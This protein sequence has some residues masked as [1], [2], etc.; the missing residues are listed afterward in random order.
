VQIKKTNHLTKLSI[1]IVGIIFLSSFINGQAQQIF[2]EQASPIETSYLDSKDELRDYI[3]DTGDELSIEFV[4]TPELSDNY[5]ID[6]QGEIFFNRL[7]YTYVRGLTI[8]E[9]TK[10]LEKRYEEFLLNPEI[11]IRITQFKPVRVAVQG[12]VRAPVRIVFPSF[13]ATSLDTNYNTNKYNLGSNN[14]IGTDSLNSNSLEFSSNLDR[15]RIKRTNDYITTLSNA[16]RGAGGLT[17]LSDISKI[18]IIRDI[19]LGKG[20]GKKKAKIDFSSYT[21]EA[22][23]TFDIRLFDGDSIFIPRLKEKDSNII[24]NSI[25]SGLSPKFMSVSISGKI[26]NPGSIRLPIEASLSDAMNLSGPRLPLSGKIFLIRYNDNGTLLRKNIKYISSSRPGSANNPYLKGDDLITVKNSILGS[27]SA[28]LKAITEPFVNIY[29]TKE[30]YE[31]I[32]G[33]N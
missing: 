21:N 17:S 20:G 27:S 30:L 13:P 22:D 16:I 24:P 29:A 6:E 15:N 5:I 28:T 7:K 18:E 12:E 2:E 1:N 14:N 31:T 33:Q 4:N 11:Y 25:L 23:T 32:S 19:P 10:L 8:K 3:L 9:L 26:E